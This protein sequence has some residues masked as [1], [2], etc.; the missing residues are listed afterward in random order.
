M[1]APVA[2]SLLAVLL[3]VSIARNALWT[4]DYAIWSK[5][6]E[7]YPRRAR[8]YN[9]LGLHML[10]AGRYEDAYRLLRMSSEL[11]PYQQQIWNNLGQVYERLGQTENAIRTYELAIGNAPQ[12]PLPY[13]NLGVLYYDRFSDRKK[14]LA[15]LLRAR[16]LQPLEPDVH[17]QLSRIY[18]DM[19]DGL[20]A[21]EE[22]K[23]YRYYRR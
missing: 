18:A 19:G 9:E 21:A 16:D 3:A 8:A 7:A 23:L 1:R 10:D 4:D 12:D 15:Y 13:Y 14:A 2:L 6:I 11:D 17:Y 20:Q 5:T 22:I